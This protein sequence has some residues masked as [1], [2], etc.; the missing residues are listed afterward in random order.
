VDILDTL[1]LTPDGVRA[2]LSGPRLTP[3]Y[4]YSAAMLLDRAADLA[5]T[6]TALTRDSEPAWR[7]WS[8]RVES[9][10]ATT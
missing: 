5:V 1:D 7:A 9:L 4:L 8:A 3:G 10:R 2:D 6:S